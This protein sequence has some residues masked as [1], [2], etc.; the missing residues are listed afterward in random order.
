MSDYFDRVERQLVDRVQGSPEPSHRWSSVFGALPPIGAVVIVLAVVAVFISVGHRAGDGSSVGSSRSSIV[1][2]ASAD[3]PHSSLGPAI[4]SSVVAL[5]HRLRSV[6]PGLRVARSGQQIVV[7]GASEKMRSRVL[8]LAVPGRL[9]FYDWEANALTPNGKPVAGQL[10][11]QEPD[12]LT[13]SQGS[14][15]LPGLPRDGAVPLYKA[16]KLASKQPVVQPAQ[17]HLS[18]LGASYY[19]FGAPGSAAC[20]TAAHSNG[21]SPIQGEHCLLAGPDTTPQSLKAGLPAGVTTSDGKRL[22]VPQ[23][24]IVLQA[25]SASASN[26][27]TASDPRAQFYVLRDNVSLTGADITN[28][29]QST[30]ESG[31]PDVTFGLNSTGAQAFQHVTATIAHRGVTASSPPQVLN[32]HFAIVLDTRLI[33]VPSIDFKT[34]PDGITGGGGADIAGVFTSHS[35][36]DLAAILRSGPLAANVAPS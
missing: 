3:S 9:R 31:R 30:D 25:A 32:Q 28:P 17:A 7:T 21:T 26:Q 13:I 33:A 4:D 27:I 8:Q 35:A 19:L 18:R 20:A 36:Q 1:F 2:Q 29:R 12:A 11:A 16:V 10:T 23:G 22:A 5:R 15:R 14:G 24:T 6:F 34:Y